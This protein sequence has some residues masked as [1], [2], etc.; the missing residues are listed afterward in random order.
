MN[1]I[2][3]QQRILRNLAVIRYQVEALNKNGQNL[4]IY[5]E[6]AIR[7]S[8]NAVTGLSWTNINAGNNNFPAV[9]LISQDGVRAVQAT[10]HTTKAKLDKTIDVVQEELAKG[11]NRLSALRDVEVVGLTCVSNRKVTSWTSIQGPKQAVRVRGIDLETLLGIANL[12]DGELD[13]L[14]Q[15]LQG[16]TTT[17]PFHLSSDHDEMRTIIAFL[18]RP[19]IR[20]RRAAEFDWQDMQDAMRSI[21]RLIGQGAN[22]TGQQITRPYPTFQPPFAALLKAIYSESAAI[23]VLLKNELRVPGSMRESEWFLLEGHR[24]RMQEH[25]TELAVNARLPAPQW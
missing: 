19:A 6:T 18:D 22:D 11:N 1:K 10:F 3:A 25:V 2:E 23:S 13:A 17:S 9:D 4:S 21:R 15:A 14:D 5:A 24:V 12:G 8:L 16:F 7:D 20:D